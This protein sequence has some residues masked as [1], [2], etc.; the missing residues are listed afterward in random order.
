MVRF[1][2]RNRNKK[3]LNLILESGIKCYLVIGVAEARADILGAAELLKEIELE[4]SIPPLFINVGDGAQQRA[5]DHLRMV[6][7][8]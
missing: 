5:Q 2:S 4:G 7:Q 6:L 1:R 3:N 8:Q